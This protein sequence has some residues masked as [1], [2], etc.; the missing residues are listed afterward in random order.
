MA[1]FEKLFT[2]EC[3]IHQDVCTR[4]NHFLRNCIKN[5]LNEL[6]ILL[7]NSKYS[8]RAYTFNYQEGRG[9]KSSLITN[10]T[11]QKQNSEK[12]RNLDE[13]ILIKLRY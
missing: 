12:I 13:K 6:W 5:S 8:H 10:K 7:K 9:C 4:K 1:C 3:Q 2:M 11:E